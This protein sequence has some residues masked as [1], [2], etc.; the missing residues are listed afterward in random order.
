M[1]GKGLFRRAGPLVIAR[2]AA[3]AIT[4]CIPLVLAR[5]MSLG[6]YGTYKQLFLVGA[7]LMNVLP[8][9][10][11]SSLYFFIPRAE[12]R[13]PFLFQTYVFLLLAG[14]VGAALVLGLLPVAGA[15]FQNGALAGFRGEL[16]G[17]VFCFLG[18]NALESTLTSQ[19]KTGASGAVYVTSE[20]F[21]AIALIVPVLLGF[22]LR[23][24]MIGLCVLTALRLCAS[25][26]LLG[27]TQGPLI[28]RAGLRRQL[29]YA[30]PFGA[31]M[32][33]ALPQQL[34]HQYMVSAHVTPEL[35]AVYSVGCFQLPLIDL[36]Y[37]PTSEVLMV[38]IGE[39]EREG[40]LEHAVGLFR[41]ASSKLAFFFLPAAAFLFV[42]APEF[43]GAMFGQKFLGAVPIFRV[44]VIAVALASLPMDGV[45][46]ARN[47]TRYLFVTYLTKAIV[48]VPLVWF[49]VLRF[50]MMGGIGAWAAAELVGKAMLLARVPRA[51][52]AGR[53]LNLFEV[54]PLVQLGKSLIAA[55]ASAIA[56]VLLRRV[57]PSVS[58]TP[59]LIGRAMPLVLFGGLFTLGYCAALTAAG[60][61]P[62]RMLASLR[63]QAA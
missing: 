11:T 41:E 53:R 20:F 54:L 42:A 34:A 15:S 37:Q 12:Q 63:R 17:Y 52:S 19:G 32:V 23:G 40:R 29:A 35:F 10:M 59:G 24:A 39:L 8:F 47:E 5:K 50:G 49:G 36:L 45:L 43:I 55:A 61:R 18:A 33:L 26:A 31:A 4:F 21:K 13:R 62:L 38:E 48:T 56:I 57:V 7:P 46:R 16:A 44:S 22:G 27:R 6:E 2:F 28:D 25:W 60:I 58:H 14:A 30:V 9:G 51:L 3:T 1:A